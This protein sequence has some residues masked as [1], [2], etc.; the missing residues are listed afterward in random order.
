HKVKE[1]K[2]ESSNNL[3]LPAS[4]ARLHKGDC[5][6]ESLNTIFLPCCSPDSSPA[7]WALVFFVIPV[8]LDTSVLTYFWTHQP[9]SHRKKAT[10]WG[11]SQCF[12]F[13]SP[14]NACILSFLH[15][16]SSTNLL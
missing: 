11:R 2:T 12:L 13:K 6:V 9:G 15:S 16:N 5:G 14:G 3:D 8:V 7:I 1:T 4:V 10:L